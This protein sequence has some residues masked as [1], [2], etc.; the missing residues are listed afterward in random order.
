MDMLNYDYFGLREANS[1]A[2]YDSLIGLRWPDS[3]TRCSICCY[4]CLAR[5]FPLPVTTFGYFLNRHF[6]QRA[7]F[8]PTDDSK[9]LEAYLYTQGASQ[10]NVHVVV[11][12]RIPRY[13]RM[14]L[15]M[16]I[17]WWNY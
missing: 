1:I 12:G 11:Y 10:E 4:D 7:F 17:R 5:F 8:F 2:H 9:I 15:S 13:D 14:I 6:L 16:K 3:I